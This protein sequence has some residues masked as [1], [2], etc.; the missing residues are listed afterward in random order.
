M[1]RVKDMT[2]IGQLSVGVTAEMQAAIEVVTAFHSV[3]PSQYG[4]RAI[5]AQLVNDGLIQHPAQRL[6]AVAAAKSA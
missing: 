4:R 6:A 3:T 1:P 2:I 5:L